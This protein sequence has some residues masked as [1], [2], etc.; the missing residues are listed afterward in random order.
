MRVPV[1]DLLSVIQPWAERHG[2]RVLGV[3]IE[4]DG[5]ARVEIDAGGRRLTLEAYALDSFG[6]VGVDLDSGGVRHAYTGPLP[7]LHGMLEEER[8]EIGRLPAPRPFDVN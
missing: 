1:Q 2:F 5:R 3:S 6:N 8:E 4:Q 7:D